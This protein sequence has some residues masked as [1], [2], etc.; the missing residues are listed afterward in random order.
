MV[1]KDGGERKFGRNDKREREQSG[2]EA[3]AAFK[4]KR[5]TTYRAAKRIAT[6]MKGISISSAVRTPSRGTRNGTR[7]IPSRKPV[8]KTRAK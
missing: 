4:A 3:L 1:L 7:M 6:N 2:G 5:Q 8:P